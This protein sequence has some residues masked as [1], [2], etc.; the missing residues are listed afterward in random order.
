VT[1]LGDKADKSAKDD[2]FR[3]LSIENNVLYF[4]KGSGSNGV[5]TVYYL[6]TSGTACAGG[7]GLPAAGATLPTAIAKN[8]TDASDY[9]FGIWF[10]SPTLLYVA[11]E[12]SGDDTYSAATNS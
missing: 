9:P 11:D 12:G 5:N 1:E 10:A 6:N 4:T 7:V 8:A 2:N 3:G